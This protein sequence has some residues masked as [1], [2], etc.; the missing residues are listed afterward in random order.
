MHDPVSDAALAAFNYCVDHTL[1]KPKTLED[2]LFQQ[3][4]LGTNQY[5]I[6]LE[7]DELGTNKTMIGGKKSVMPFDINLGAY[8]STAHTSYMMCFL[9][10]DFIIYVRPDLVVTRLGL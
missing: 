1:Q 2:W 4:T 10:A 6:S 3:M 7:G 5:G 9:R 8:K